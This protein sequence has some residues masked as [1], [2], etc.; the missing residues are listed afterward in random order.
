MWR[1]FFVPAILAS[2]T[3]CVSSRFTT[4]KGP[5]GTP[6]QL[7]KC[8]QIEKCY[9]DAAKVCEKYKIVNT[10]TLT[11]GYENNTITEIQVLVKCE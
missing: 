10:S 7:I 5:D 11:R 2:L 9:E 8:V 1:L 6:H 4:I 3:S